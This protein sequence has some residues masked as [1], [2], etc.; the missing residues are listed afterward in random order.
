MGAILQL[1]KT[2]EQ[3]ISIFSEQIQRETEGEYSVQPMANGYIELQYKGTGLIQILAQGKT[4]KKLY[5]DIGILVRAFL[6][7]QL[8]DALEL[9]EKE[10][11]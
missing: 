3:R 6:L 10:Q 5:E 1:P 11:A 7:H 2:Y 9:I 8:A 4:Y